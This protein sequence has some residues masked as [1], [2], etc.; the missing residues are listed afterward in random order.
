MIAG[1][2]GAAALLLVIAGAGKVVDPTRTVGALR[3]VGWPASGLL[4]R[5]GAVGETL[6]GAATLTYGGRVLPLLV[7]A[8]YLGFAL[9]VMT[10]L[11][12]GT[13]VA[14]CGC[15]TRADTPPSVTHVVVNGLLA[16]GA[17]AAG[18]TD[19]PALLDASWPAWVVAGAL[20]AYVVLAFLAAA[21]GRTQQDERRA[22][23]GVPPQA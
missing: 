7:A 17:V 16:A 12:A 23:G 8:S 19:A 18:A 11:R 3:A 1:V 4:V 21:P 10:A 6:L 9:F 15:L 14:T 2:V 20:T 13:P 5:A 22:A